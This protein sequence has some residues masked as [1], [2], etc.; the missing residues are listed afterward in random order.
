[1]ATAAAVS[2]SDSAKLSSHPKPNGKITGFSLSKLI[3]ELRADWFKRDGDVRPSRRKVSIRII[4]AVLRALADYYPNIFPS[5]NTIAEHAGVG[6][7][8]ARNALRELETQ[9]WIAERIAEGRKPKA[10]GRG[11]GTHYDLSVSKVVEAI[12]TQD[13]ETQR[14]PLPLSDTNPTAPAQ[15]AMGPAE[16]P[17]GPAQNP[18]GAVAE[19]TINRKKEKIEKREKTASPSDAGIISISQTQNLGLQEQNLVAKEY[20]VWLAGTY[21]ELSLSARQRRDIQNFILSTTYDQSVL[22]IATGKILDLL[23]LADS[24]AQA[25]SRLTATL[26]DKAEAIERELA[27]EKRH[28]LAVDQAAKEL[29]EQAHKATAELMQERAEEEMAAQT[30]EEIFG[31]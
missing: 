30:K 13:A 27:R 7:S 26:P 12:A 31:K 5:V 25:A 4:K 6:S 9:G 8:T 14:E 24:Y 1:M 3:A 17:T 19:Q 16:N 28:Q 11:A 23:D 29:E 10:G 2:L 15:K 18:T 21:L 22:R 20:F